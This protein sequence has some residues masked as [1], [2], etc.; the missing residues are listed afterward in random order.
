LPAEGVAVAVKVVDVLAQVMVPAA[1]QLTVGVVVFVAKVV[2]PEA[3]QP[4]PLC[5][6]VTV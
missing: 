2:D 5:T 1:A 3:V 4:L 6:T